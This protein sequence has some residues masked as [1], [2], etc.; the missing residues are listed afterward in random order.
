LLEQK[1]YLEALGQFQKVVRMGS[2]R[3]AAE[4]QFLIGRT[5]REQGQFATSIDELIKVRANHE[6]HM[7]WILEAFLLIA[8]N[9]ISLNNNF[10]ARATLNSIVEVA[11]D[12]AVRERAR[13]RLAEI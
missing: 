11:N 5:L 2:D 12:E 13:K 7:E 3:N 8:E 1:N 9:Y 4:A 6:S 10:Q